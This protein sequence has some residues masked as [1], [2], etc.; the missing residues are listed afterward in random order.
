MNDGVKMVV[1]LI[2]DKICNHP[3][4]GH[5]TPHHPIWPFPMTQHHMQDLLMG[6]HGDG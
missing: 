2:V 3:H 1:F 6:L 5:F 4:H